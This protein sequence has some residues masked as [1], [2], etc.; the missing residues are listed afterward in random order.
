MGRKMFSG[1]NYTKML[2]GG[3]LRAIYCSLYLKT[4]GNVINFFISV[5]VSTCDVSAQDVE[6]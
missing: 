4:E 6:R 5:E 1:V 3:F 2:L